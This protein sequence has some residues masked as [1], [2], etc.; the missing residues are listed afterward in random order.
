MSILF[1]QNNS[2]NNEIRPQEADFTE[3][4]C[5]IAVVPKMLYFYGKMPEK[6][7]KSVAIVGTR[8]PTTYGREI[9]YDLAYKAAKKGAVV[10]SGL[11]FGI[12][13]VAHRGALDAGGVTVAV[14]GTAIDQIYP[15]AHRG[16]A[17]EIV[18]K[19]G[20]VMS[21][22]APGVRLDFRYQAKK[23]FLERNRLI[24]GLS[25]VVVIP[26]A[27]ERSG[28]LNTA[29]HA[30]DQGR[31]ILAV[32][33]DL[34]RPMSMGCNRLIAKGG[35]MPYLGTDDVLEMLFPTPRRR[36]KAQAGQLELFGDNEAETT[37]LGLLAG[38]MVEGEEILVASGLEVSEF[39]QQMTLLEVKGR[40][41]ALGA[42]RWA[43]ERKKAP[44][45]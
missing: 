18:R 19:G 15:A 41:R 20:M 39:S 42:N 34:T 38:G 24:A 35:A 26:E 28:S 27:A 2:K 7:L 8:K 4:L 23:C 33:G 37:I 16:L 9:A 43:L 12:D 14:L 22:I 17:E 1:S 13:S 25:D 32:P 45:S 31:E 21:E 6:R 10:V 30:L 29:M 36:G 40:V 44:V 3:V 11:A 5:H